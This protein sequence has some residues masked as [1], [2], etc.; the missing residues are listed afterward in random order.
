MRATLL[1]VIVG[2]LSGCSCEKDPQLAG[3]TL[4]K[5]LPA[6]PARK[7]KPYNATGELVESD[8][9]LFGVR[10]P[11]GL[12]EGQVNRKKVHVFRTPL[13]TEKVSQYFLQRL[14]AEH[15]EPRGKG[16]VLHRARPLDAPPE[17]DRVYLSVHTLGS[18][19][20]VEIE[21]LVEP[22]MGRDVAAMV[23]EYNK[24]LEKAE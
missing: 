16:I 11:V 24:A 17:G 13:S 8:E 7:P 20:R 9:V 4:R 5:D 23:K 18:G 14:D 10:L 6:K 2:L 19:T 3:E 1:V 15:I 22:P 21:K 12:G